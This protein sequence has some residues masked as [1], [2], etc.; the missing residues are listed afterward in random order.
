MKIPTHFQRLWQIGKI[1]RQYGLDT[2][3]EP[4]LKFRLGQAPDESAVWRIR[5]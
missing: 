1:V 3:L 4:Y 2:D 5:L